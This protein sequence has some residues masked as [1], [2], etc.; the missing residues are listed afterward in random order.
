M[1]VIKLR[2][3]II[4]AIIACILMIGFNYIGS[5]SKTVVSDTSPTAIG[6]KLPIIMYHGITTEQ[7]RVGKY[8]ISCDMFKSDLKYL[9]DNGYTTILI[10]D[11]IDYV[12]ADG[13]LPNKPI[14]LTFD[15]GYYN[16]YVYAYEMLKENNMKAVI[17]I[18]G[19]W[20]D[21]Y[22]EN[23]EPN[24]IYSHLTW[25]NI[26]ELLDSGIIE[27]QNHSYDM[28]TINNGRNG[29]KKKMGESDIDY[30]VALTGDIERLQN[31]FKANTLNK[32]S[33]TCFTYP[34]GS[35]SPESQAIIKD[36]G[37]KASLSCEEKINIIEK[38]NPE[39]LYLMKRYLRD[40]VTSVEKILQK[41]IK[42]D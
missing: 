20:T 14:L 39:C 28:H 22:T 12:N 21:V 38:G 23:E 15:D 1:Y 2:T 9:K 4:Y 34:Y 36:I 3:L 6:L 35:I 40:N 5:D 19:K 25:D 26:N 29:T 10:K 32:Y 17:S 18:I 30:K 33:P 42:Q 27:I 7:K 13:T 16:N 24:P 8:V 11:L 41:S 31:E 37:F